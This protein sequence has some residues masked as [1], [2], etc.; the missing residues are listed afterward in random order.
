MTDINKLT[1][2]IEQIREASP[3]AKMALADQ[4]LAQALGL[5]QAYDTQ[6]AAQRVSVDN[7]TDQ[8]GHQAA[9][10][11]ELSRRLNAAKLEGFHG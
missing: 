4:A 8:V 7:L 11:D 5:F 10:I 9:R 2:T 1:R 6:L 3:L